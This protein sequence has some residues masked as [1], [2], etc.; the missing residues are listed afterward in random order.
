MMPSRP[1]SSAPGERRRRG[2][3]LCAKLASEVEK[4]TP[5]GI[6]RWEP[7]WDLVSDAGIRFL[8]ALTS[9]EATGREEQWSAVC[10]AVNSVHRAWH[11]AAREYE[12]REE[13]AERYGD[14]RA[15]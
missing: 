4:M 1:L 5:S 10:I 9:W 14:W 2:T 8:I 15:S 3:I 7:A 12:E 11:E 6:A 13:W